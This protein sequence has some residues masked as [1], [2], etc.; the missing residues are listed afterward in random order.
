MALL[1]NQRLA[2]DLIVEVPES[3]ESGTDDSS[4]QSNEA[5]PQTIQ[6]YRQLIQSPPV[7]LV[8]RLPASDTPKLVN[9]PETYNQ[10]NKCPICSVK[11]LDLGSNFRNHIKSHVSQEVK[12]TIVTNQDS[13]KNYPSPFRIPSVPSVRRNSQ[14]HQQS[15][16]TSRD[17]IVRAQRS[18]TRIEHSLQLDI[19]APANPIPMTLTWSLMTFTILSNHQMTNYGS[20]NYAKSSFASVLVF[21]ATINRKLIEN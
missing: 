1:V 5:E 18:I 7:V 20:V 21:C 12:E 14:A 6:E 4:N 16:V 3:S 2:E 10:W 15:V 17:F 19:P 9:K 11:V 13:L 8:Q